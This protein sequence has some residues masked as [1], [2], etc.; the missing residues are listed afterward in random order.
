MKK[1]RKLITTLILST[2]A[3]SANAVTMAA[4]PVVG[5]TLNGVAVALQ[6][7]PLPPDL[8]MLK[9]AKLSSRNYLVANNNGQKQYYQVYYV[10]ANNDGSLEYVLTQISLGN[11]GP[12]SIVDAFR[13]SNNT[14]SFLNFNQMAGTQLELG[15]PLAAC[16]NW[17]C[18][19]AQPAF[20]YEGNVW[21]MRFKNNNGQMC[22]YLWKNNQFSNQPATPGCIGSNLSTKAT[23]NPANVATTSVPN[24]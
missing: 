20:V 22:Q 13:M 10:D 11:T 1:S 21:Y 12:S 7:S 9:T 24:Q 16:K 5:D 14:L 2:M 15:G 18:S 3:L 8:Q 4:Q 19:L 23:P 6:T 17:Y